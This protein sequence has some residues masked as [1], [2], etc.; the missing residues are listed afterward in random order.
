MDFSM[1]ISWINTP[2][3]TIGQTPLTFSG[4][5]VALHETSVRLPDGRGSLQPPARVLTV[6]VSWIVAEVLDHD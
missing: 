4:I 5:G 3:V 1:L 2:L 6:K